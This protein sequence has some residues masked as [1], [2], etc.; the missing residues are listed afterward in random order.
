MKNQILSRMI[1]P[2]NV[3]SYAGTILSVFVSPSGRSARHESL[4]NESRNDPLKLLPPD[5][6]IMFTTPPLKRPYSAE[7]FPVE[8]FV[9]WMASST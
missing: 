7:M 1:G 2:P 5:L 4:V 6:V 9:S 8:I 3:P